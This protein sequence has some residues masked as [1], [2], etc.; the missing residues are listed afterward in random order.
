MEVS[1]KIMAL[2][3]V[4]LPSWAIFRTLSKGQNAH[5]SMLLTHCNLMGLLFWG[6]KQFLKQK[7]KKVF[8]GGLKAIE[9]TLRSLGG[10]TS[11][12]TRLAMQLRY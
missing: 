7:R 11:T 12:Y 1:P 2:F 10:L 5:N 3:C 4:Y 6:I 9:G 8:F